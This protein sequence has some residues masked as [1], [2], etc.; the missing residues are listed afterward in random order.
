MNETKRNRREI[1]RKSERV[2]IKGKH[3]VKLII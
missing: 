1:A 3:C 2:R